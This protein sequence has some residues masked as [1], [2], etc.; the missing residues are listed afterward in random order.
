MQN[1]FPEGINEKVQEKYGVQVDAHDT[2]FKG[3]CQK[4]KCNR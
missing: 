4:C 2:I 1:A 3:I